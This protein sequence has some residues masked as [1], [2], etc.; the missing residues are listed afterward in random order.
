MTP[1]E[2]VHEPGSQV[3]VVRVSGDLD[4]AVVPD[5]RA[6][7]DRVFDSG[8]ENVVL[9]L[10]QVAYADS[11]ALGL[12]VWVDHRLRPISGRLVI[13]GASG[14]VSRILE[15]SGLVSVAATI[16]MSGSVTSALEGLELSETPSEQLWERDVVVEADVN[17]LA[18]VREHVCDVLEPLGF[19]ESALFDVKV[20]LGEALANAIRHGSPNEGES[21]IRVKI[22]AYPERIVLEVLDNGPGFDGAHSGSEDLYAPGGRGIMFMRALMDRVEYGAPPSGGT[23]VRL[24]KHRALAR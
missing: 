6:G 2:L 10:D 8:C 5:L 1:F 17:S 3:C 13:A 9:D 22:R 20:A 19:S 21:E 16:G 14:D 24:T 11:S 12:L 23:L 4:M 15:L 7:L 18:G